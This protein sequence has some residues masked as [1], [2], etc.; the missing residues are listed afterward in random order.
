[1][2]I[3]EVPTRRLA[4]SLHS[5]PGAL[6][7]TLH[8]ARAKLRGELVHDDIDDYLSRRRPGFEGPTCSPPASVVGVP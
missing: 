7:K 5:T 3:D 6:Y 1:M 2:T 4:V 8:D